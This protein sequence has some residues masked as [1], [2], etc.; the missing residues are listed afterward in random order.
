M[1]LNML[2]SSEGL[3]ERAIAF[4]YSFVSQLPSRGQISCS[5]LKIISDESNYIN[6]MEK[7]LSDCWFGLL[8]FFPSRVSDLSFLGGGCW[9]TED[10]NRPQI[11]YP[12][13]G[14]SIRLRCPRS[15]CNFKPKWSQKQKEM[16]H[17]NCNQAK[18][19]SVTHNR[20]HFALVIIAIPQEHL[21]TQLIYFVHG[22]H[23]TGSNT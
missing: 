17:V 1:H 9:I 6:V 5:R 12:G 4:C 23:L 16:L 15:L 8:F 2:Q 18:N 14:A 22:L 11:Q 10:K 21:G 3:T 19:T 20:L 7:M 13:H